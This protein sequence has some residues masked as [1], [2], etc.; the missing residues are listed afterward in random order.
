MEYTA[1]MAR[2]LYG[3]RVSPSVIW[4]LTPW[5]WAIDWASNAGD[6]LQ[7]IEA[8]SNDGLV[9][10]YGYIM[11]EQSVR[12]DRRW[13]GAYNRV[14]LTTADAYGVTSKV[15]ERATPYGFGLDPDGFSGSQLSILAALGMTRRR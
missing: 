13:K 15:R 4:N 10:R 14:P 2:R 8:F 5:T 9:M 7:N 1:D 11:S 12:Y 3:V 6:V